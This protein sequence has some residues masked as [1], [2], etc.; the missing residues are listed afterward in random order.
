MKVITFVI[1]ALL[2]FITIA[3]AEEKVIP[4]RD[5]KDIAGTWEGKVDGPGWSTPMTCIY[6]EDGTGDCVVPE[7]SPVFAF[8]DKGRFPL[9]RDLVEGKI[10]SKNLITGTASIVTLY[11]EEG[12]RLLKTLSEDGTQKGVYEPASKSKPGIATTKK[13]DSAPQVSV[14]MA[15]FQKAKEKIT[16]KGVEREYYLFRSGNPAPGGRPLLFVLHGS[17]ASAEIILGFKTGQLTQLAEKEGFLVVFPNGTQDPPGAQGRHW[18]DGRW[19]DGRISFGKAVGK[20]EDVAFFEAMIDLFVKREGV[21]PKKVYL[22][23]VSQGG[24]MAFRLALDMPDR[25]A[26][27]GIVTANM[28]VY[29]KDRKVTTPVS[30]LIMNGTKDPLMPYKG[31]TIFG[32]MEISSAPETALFWARA[33][34]C[35]QEP[36][37]TLLPDVRP[38]D[39]TR[40][41]RLDYPGCRKGIEVVFYSIENGGHTWPNGDQYWPES[42]IGKVTRD[43]DANQILMGFF[44]NK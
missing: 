41:T 29:L 24:T 1:L 39:G 5:F 14:P 40:V 23:G 31:G 38:D 22:A 43:I 11:E 42:R 21:D 10:R 4:I 26:A 44:K 3:Q 19:D 17:P 35:K 2:M 27:F 34:G 18:N 25:F 7:G 8:S 6:N 30:M 16:V 9:K 36:V 13:A 33:A 32:P 28:P 37:A 20:S 12:N 15:A